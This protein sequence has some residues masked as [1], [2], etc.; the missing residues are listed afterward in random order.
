MVSTRTATYDLVLLLDIGAEERARAAILAD[1][2]RAISADGELL[3]HDEWG[4]RAL[5]YPIRHRDRAEY[6]LFQFHPAKADLLRGLDRSLRIADPVIRFRIVK[7]AAGTP[8]PPDSLR[9]G[10][11]EEPHAGEHPGDRGP[12]R[13]APAP[14]EASPQGDGDR[15]SAEAEGAGGAAEAAREVPTAGDAASEAPQAGGVTSE[16]GAPAGADS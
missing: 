5:A 4:E 8:D 3:R 12:A 10:R 13:S 14:R 1:V 6:H 15:P 2:E 16:T 11:A 7:L 9:A